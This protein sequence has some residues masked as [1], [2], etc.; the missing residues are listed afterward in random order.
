MPETTATQPALYRRP[1][2]STNLKFLN[3]I[4]VDGRS[5]IEDQALDATMV[6]AQPTAPP[7]D[8][9]LTQIVSLESS[10]FT[11]QS[12]DTQPETSPRRAPP[13]ALWLFRLSLLS[14][15]NSGAAFTPMFLPCTQM[16]LRHWRKR[17]RRSSPS[18]AESCCSIPSPWSFRRARIQR[19]SGGTS[20]VGTCSTCHDTPNVGGDSLPEM[21]DIGTSSPNQSPVLRDHCNDGTQICDVRSWTGDGH[22]QMRRP[23]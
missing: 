1:L 18:R 3:G 15:D 10:V 19:R 14:R 7:T 16:G 8:A 13:A 5:P 12:V 23:E 20:I 21:M 11:A 9:Q 2:P 4:M 22:G 17:P 6:H